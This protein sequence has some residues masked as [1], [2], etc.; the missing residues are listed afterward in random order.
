MIAVDDQPSSIINNQG[1]RQVLQ[2]AEP[3][4]TMPND[5]YLRQTAAPDLYKSVHAQVADRVQSVKFVSFTTDTWT[6]S[7]S[8][9]SL[10]SLTGHWIDD[11]GKRRAAILQTSHLPGSHTAATI[12]TKFSKMLTAWSL[13]EKESPHLIT[14]ALN[15]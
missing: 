3:R 6:T 11:N 7:M 4:Y 15:E 14:V 5:T 10:I 9:E 1:F 13:E 8:S 12:K 2:L